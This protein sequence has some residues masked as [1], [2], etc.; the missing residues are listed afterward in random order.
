[1]IRR[2]LLALALALGVIS[3][4]HAQSNGVTPGR[5]ADGAIEGEFNVTDI[6]QFFSLVR[7]VAGQD[8]KKRSV[9]IRVCNPAGNSDVYFNFGAKGAL[10]VTVTPRPDGTRSPRISSNTCKEF[11]N[12]GAHSAALMTATGE[13]ANGVVVTSMYVLQP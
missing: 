6:G 5:L 9:A 11:R 10:D 7:H 3:A 13:T 4:G 8:T 2:L 12:A 1:M